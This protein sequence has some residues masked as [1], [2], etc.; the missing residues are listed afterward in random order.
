M[1]TVYNNRVFSKHE[2]KGWKAKDDMSKTWVHLQLYFGDICD[3][4]KKY[5]PRYSRMRVWWIDDQPQ[6]SNERDRCGVSHQQRVPNSRWATLLENSLI[7]LSTSKQESNSNLTPFNNNKV[8]PIN[9]LQPLQSIAKIWPDP[10]EGY[11][12][13][14]LCV[15]TKGICSKWG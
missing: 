3:A 9:K 7:P 10:K 2:L 15:A 8:Q 13:Y 4:N 14:W 5:G 1:D 11:Q 6:R 12:Q